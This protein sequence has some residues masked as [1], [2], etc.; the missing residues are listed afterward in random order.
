MDTLPTE[1]RPAFFMYTDYTFALHT[2]PN[3]QASIWPHVLTLLYELKQACSGRLV[4][5]SNNDS[6]KSRTS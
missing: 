2:A 6:Q 4:T 1:S 3:R 5:I